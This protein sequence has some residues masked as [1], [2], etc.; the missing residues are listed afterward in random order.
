VLIRHR[1]R[2]LGWITVEEPPDPIP[3]ERITREVSCQ[4]GRPLE[5]AALLDSLAAPRE[6]TDL[7]AI[8]VVVCTRNRAASLRRCLESL[9]DLDYP[10]YEVIVVDNASVTRETAEITAR[11]PFRSVREERPG[12][13]WA[14]NR[15]IAEARHEIVAFTDDDVQVDRLWLRGVAEG[16]EEPDVMLVTG[17]TAPAELVTEAQ[18][19]FEFCY[20][21]MS[22]GFRSNRWNPAELRPDQI[23]GAHRLGV[24]ANMAFRR[25]VFEQVGTFDTSLDVGT[26]SHGGGDLDM[27]H[28]VLA[29][30]QVARYNP[31]ALVRHC[32]RRDLA[33]LHR[34][35]RDNGRA[36]GVYLLSQSFPGD[37]RQTG[38]GKGNLLRYALRIWLGWLG[39]R[40]L[41]RL[42]RKETM[43]LPLQAS[44]LLGVLQAPWAFI[45]TRRSDCQ[46]RRRASAPII[47]SRVAG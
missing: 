16:F 17:F 28:R 37:V 23:I 4:L 12:L 10:T 31:S 20:G 18:V 15:G 2:P 35:L 39:G 24:G 38:I 30:G 19:M 13:D 3:H 45:A 9:R 44:E 32:H 29:G 26:P 33:A 47:Q 36:F 1:G 46:I 43:S 27:F 34:Q 41:R 25:A 11:F 7:P 5:E 8:S 14:R 6:R 22:K 40:V 42:A 21:G